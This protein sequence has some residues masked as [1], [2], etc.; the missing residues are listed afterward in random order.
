MTF[1]PLFP[2]LP[3][4]TCS[5]LSTLLQFLLPTS[6]F[7]HHFTV[8]RQPPQLKP[9]KQ[10]KRPK[11]QPL[12]Q[13]QPWRQPQITRDQRSFLFLATCPLQPTGNVGRPMENVVPTIIV[14]VQLGIAK[15]ME[16]QKAS[17]GATFYLPKAFNHVSSAMASASLNQT[18]RLAVPIGHQHPRLVQTC[19]CPFKHGLVP[20]VV[21]VEQE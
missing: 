20:K 17:H 11:R 14:A 12:L 8:L 15:M 19:R 9:P 2:T 21:A 7:A 3:S 10:P 6:A 1:Q 5:P 16:A 13:D 4:L 18:Y